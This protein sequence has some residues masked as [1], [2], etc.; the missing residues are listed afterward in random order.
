[1]DD[2]R[3]Q[4][5]PNQVRRMILCSGKVYVDLVTSERRKDSPAIAIVRVEQLYRFPVEELQSVL[6]GYPHL[7]EVIWLQEE[8]ENMGAWAFVRQYLE[9]LIH[10][11]WLLCYMGR[12]ANSSP[13]EGS[14]TWFAANQKITIERAYDL[15]T[16]E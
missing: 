13:A 2:D 1:M 6:N 3:A 11:R 14:S 7:K 9:E 8:P 12:P 16:R 4:Q 5:K 15:G 10:G